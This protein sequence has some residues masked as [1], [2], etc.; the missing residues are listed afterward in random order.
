MK[1]QPKRHEDATPKPAKRDRSCPQRQRRTFAEISQLSHNEVKVELLAVGLRPLELVPYVEH[2]GDG[3][4]PRP[5]LEEHQRYDRTEHDRLMY[6]DDPFVRGR[7]AQQPQF[8]LLAGD[9]SRLHGFELD[10]YVE[11]LSLSTIIKTLETFGAEHRLS[12]P[13]QRS[14][15]DK[16]YRRELCT[17]LSQADHEDFVRES[18]VIESTIKRRRSTK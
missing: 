12:R 10:R 18:P 13:P 2:F 17:R 16:D 14:W 11:S 1:A 3:P 7:L 9:R 8:D 15:N 4:N 5:P 6:S